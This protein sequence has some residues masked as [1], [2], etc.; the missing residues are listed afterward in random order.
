MAA[1][2][3]A[4]RRV[5]LV[6]DDD[7]AQTSAT[8]R[9]LR[10]AGYEAVA[11]FD[12]ESALVELSKLSIRLAL[13]DMQLGSERGSDLIAAMLRDH[14][15]LS[16]VLISGSAPEEVASVANECGAT[17]YLTKPLVL[18]RLIEIIEAID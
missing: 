8:V 5:I 15:T 16:T 1:G 3:S 10:I 13:V 14:P 7:R 12:A 17:A 2:D 9:L 11:A 18:D 6:V 4:S